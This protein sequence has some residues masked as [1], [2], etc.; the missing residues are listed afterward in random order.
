LN[1][2]QLAIPAG[3]GLLSSGLATISNTN[4]YTTNAILLTYIQANST[5]AIIVV[6]NIINGTSFQV[7]STA[8]KDTNRFS[9][10]I[11]FPH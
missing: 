5:N 9:W 11:L 7:A 6:T 10:T 1:A 3:I 4:A 8:A 2:S